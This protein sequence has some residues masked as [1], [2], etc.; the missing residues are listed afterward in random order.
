MRLLDAVNVPWRSLANG[1]PK[2]CKA[3]PIRL[4]YFI[5]KPSRETFSIE[6]LFDAI[7]SAIPEQRFVI[8]RLICP[9][10]STG[11]FRR[12][13]LIAWAAIRQGDINHVTGDVDFL[14][15]LM[16][17]RRTVITI[18]DINS[19][20]RLRGL[21]R[22]V[23]ELFWLRLPLFRAGQVTTA[24][25]AS[26]A[27]IQPFAAR[28]A[29]P[30][31]VIPDCMTMRLEIQ[32]K[33]FKCHLPRILHVGTKPN[34]NLERV[35]AALRGVPCELV[36][37]GKV[38]HEQTHLLDRSGIHYENHVDLSDT[39]LLDQYRAADLVVFVSTYE[40]FGL[41]ILEAQAIGRPVVTSDHE[42]MRSV[43]G[44]GAK[45]VDP[46]DVDEIRRGIEDVIR[47]AALRETLIEAGRRNVDRYSP[48]AVALQ[49]ASLYIEMYE[50]MHKCQGR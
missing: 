40:G 26:R 16:R 17:R 49:Y 42:P 31:K 14:C 8:R 39:A 43:A 9:F 21:R 23:Y 11:I 48:A 29:R 10:H 4:H 41:P 28:A 27:E 45:L 13:L 24:S 33:S 50:E 5:R 1:A 22:R 7:I 25:E 30:I 12:I 36:V 15:L 38:T 35:I 6:R 44:T 3:R 19:L 32:P 46:T 34:K 2:S 37:V 20:H 47:N 18:H